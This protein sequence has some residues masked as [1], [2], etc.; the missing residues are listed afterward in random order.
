MQTKCFGMVVETCQ[1]LPHPTPVSERE[2]RRPKPKLG[3]AK[4]KVGLS[5]TGKR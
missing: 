3:C 2:S 5:G 1:N 4:Q